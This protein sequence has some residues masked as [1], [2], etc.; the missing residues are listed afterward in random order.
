MRVNK[1]TKYIYETTTTQLSVHCLH[2]F[3]SRNMLE[4][5]KYKT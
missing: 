3:Y 5:D 4:S 2:V 1:N